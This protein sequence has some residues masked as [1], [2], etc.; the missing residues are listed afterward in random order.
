M[1]R[2]FT[3]RCLAPLALGAIALVAASCGDPLQPDDHPDAGGVV[4]FAEGTR[5]VLAMSVG[6]GVAFDN[7]ITVPLGGT[8]E[9]EVLFL[10]ADDPAN[11][12]LAF[13]PRAAEGESLRATVANP[14]I[15]GF[16]LHG[17]HADFEGLAPGTTTVRFDL[18]HGS[19]SDFASGPLTVTVQ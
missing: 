10:D 13:L 4:V 16:D 7:P 19:H 17:D 3:T 5:N 9:V 15:A 11:L 1:I 14:A 6:A 18:M 8:L 12:D 2:R